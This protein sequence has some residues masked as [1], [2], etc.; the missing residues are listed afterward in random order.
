[1]KRS[2]ILSVVWLAMTLSPAHIVL[3]QDGGNKAGEDKSVTTT[4]QPSAGGGDISS[5]SGKDHQGNSPSVP[6]LD[7]NQSAQAEQDNPQNIDDVPEENQRENLSGRVNTAMSG[8]PTSDPI[9]YDDPTDTPW[10]QTPEDSNSGM[11]GWLTLLLAVAALAVAIYNYYTLHPKKDKKRSSRQQ[12]QASA[13]ESKQLQEL[14]SQNRI[15]SD[16]I[17]RLT[18]Q[19]ND[20]EARIGRLTRQSQGNPTPQ[21]GNGGGGTPVQ[22][23]QSNPGTATRYA[24]TVLGDGFPEDSL[25]DANSNYVIA[26]LSIKGDAGSFVINDQSGAQSFLISNFA[27]G[28]G[29]VCDIQQQNSSP[30]RV[31]TNRP[32]TVQRQGNSWKV[33]T[34]A[35]VSLV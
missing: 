5:S 14:V 6:P 4:Q 19:V 35:Q 21:G 25:T 12:E 29:R 10:Q 17:S 22:Q 8:S 30:T 27:Y 24:T 1:M 16:S 7:K 28:A 13:S 2:I 32:G 18:S 31:Q 15:L 20:M 11:M 3:A 23:Q 34:K 9:D 26:V 33:T